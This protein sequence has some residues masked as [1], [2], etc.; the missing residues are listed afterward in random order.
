MRITDIIRTVLDIVHQA[1]QPAQE[2]MVAIAVSEPD[3]ETMDM[4]TLAGILKVG[5]DG[6]CDGCGRDPC[7]C[8]DAGYANEPKEIIAP[9]QAA[10]PSGTDLNRQKQQNPVGGFTGDNP[11]ARN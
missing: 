2:P 11:M 7:G 6:A 3:Q 5:D 9:M 4:Q 10:F 1:E 8:D